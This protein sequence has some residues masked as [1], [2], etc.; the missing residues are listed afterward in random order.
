[1]RSASSPSPAAHLRLAPGAPVYFIFFYFIL[2]THSVA[3]LRL[4]LLPT[5]L[6]LFFT[7]YALYFILYTRSSADRPKRACRL[8][9]FC[10]TL[11]F[12]A[13]LSFSRLD[14]ALWLP[15]RAPPH[16]RR[17]PPP[18]ALPPA[19]LRARCRCPASFPRRC[20]SHLL[21]RQRPPTRIELRR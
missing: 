6:E 12:Y 8:E 7:L 5:R 13:G 3:H 10:Y 21:R 2:Y 18:L 20:S 16:L 9:L 11:Y 19:R 17:G 4:A 1:M 14:C 15:R